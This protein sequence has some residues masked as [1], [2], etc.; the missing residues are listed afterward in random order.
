MVF[1][2]IKVE[3]HK[4]IKQYEMLIILYCTVY[5][6][7]GYDIVKHCI[8]SRTVYWQESAD[9]ILNKIQGLQ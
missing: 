1:L 6:C 7:M 9:T 4:E 8:Y 3:K 5:Y 2:Y